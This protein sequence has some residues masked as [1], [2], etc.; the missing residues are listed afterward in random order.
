MKSWL[1]EE[2]A[3]GRMNCCSMR[4]P[5][6]M[7]G[8]VKVENKR[9]GGEKARARARHWAGPVLRDLEKSHKEI[10]K[11]V[12]CMCSQL[13]TLS[14]SCKRW[15]WRV[16]LLFD[17]FWSLYCLDKVHCRPHVSV[18]FKC[19]TWEG[20]TW[21]E[22]WRVDIR[23]DPETENVNF[24][25]QKEKKVQNNQSFPIDGNPFMMEKQLSCILIIVTRV[26][27]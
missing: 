25:L 14:C 18:G 24:R 11:G 4:G 15:K 19:R 12:L 26:V 20:F 16:E 2:K 17:Y 27:A 7:R 5:G 13:E 10:Y 9:V 23:K 6:W 22:P 8:N 3:R 21:M 1:K